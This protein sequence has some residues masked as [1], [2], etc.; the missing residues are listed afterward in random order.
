MIGQ[1]FLRIK[2]SMNMNKG[3]I[4][5]FLFL[6]DFYHFLMW[7]ETNCSGCGKNFVRIKTYIKKVVE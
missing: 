3:R 2:Y 5:I 1:I 7:H 6:S 4:E